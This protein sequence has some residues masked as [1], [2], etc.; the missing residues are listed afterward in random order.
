[1]GIHF[2]G[3]IVLRYPY[4]RQFFTVLT[5]LIFKNMI[6]IMEHT[7]RR[8]VKVFS[9]VYEHKARHPLG[10]LMDKHAADRTT[11][12]FARFWKFR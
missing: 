2:L 7:F 10:I 12:L 4:Q 3:R 9:S 5:G 8:A 11:I 6:Q 1:M